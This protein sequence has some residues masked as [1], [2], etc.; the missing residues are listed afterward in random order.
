MRSRPSFGAW[1]PS[2]TDRRSRLSEAP[3]GA[4]RS[5][6]PAPGDIEESRAAK[7]ERQRTDGRMAMAEHQAL[8]K[9]VDERT[10]ALRALRLA[11][12]AAEA[13]PEA[14]PSAPK[15]TARKPRRPF[16]QG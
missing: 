11:R 6:P 13:T 4:D 1:S 12:E 5:T 16:T 8:Q 15:R 2:S 10:A 14:G 3:L 9:K 7:R